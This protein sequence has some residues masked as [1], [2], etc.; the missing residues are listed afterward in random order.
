LNFGE[1]GG[2]CV[3]VSS[4]DAGSWV[5]RSLVTPLSAVRAFR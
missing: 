3:L 5:Y 2:C 4:G 1:Q